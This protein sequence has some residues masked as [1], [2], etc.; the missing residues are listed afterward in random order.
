MTDVFQPYVGPR[1]FESQDLELFFARDSEANELVSLI[2]SHNLVLVYAQSGAGKTSLIN[3]KLVPMLTKDEGFEVLPVVRG[4]RR[5]LP[6]GI[7]LE[8]I[9]S[10]Y[11]FT[12]LINWID[13][14][15]SGARQLI[16]KPMAKFFAERPRPVDEDGLPCHRAI[17]F[18]QFEEFFRLY[19]ER[20]KDREDFFR[21]LS[22]AME[23]EPETQKGEK[24]DQ[25]QQGD[26][27]LHVVL[28][29]RED[30]IASL[31]EY[32]SY[33]PGNLRS[34]FRLEPLREKA[35]LSAI[36]GPLKGTKYSWGKAVPET[37]VSDLL[38]NKVE[39]GTGE[40]KEV[41]GKFVEPLQLQV[42][43]QSL[44]QALPAGVSQIT[45]DHLRDYGDTDGALANFYE[46]A[47]KAAATETEVHENS[48]REWCE[49]WLI[50]S[51]GTRGFVHRDPK[52]T[53]SQQK[54]LA[55]LEDA[56]LIRSEFRAGGYWYELSHDRFVS[57]IKASNENWNQARQAKATEVLSTLNGVF[58]V[59]TSPFIGSK[60]LRP[61]LQDCEKSLS[62]SREIGEG[63]LAAFA[64]GYMGNIYSREKQYTDALAA[65]EQAYQLERAAGDQ[66]GMKQ[67][68]LLEGDVYWELERFEEA[69]NC[70]TEYIGLAPDDVVGYERRAATY[71]YSGNH[72]KAIADYDRVIELNSNTA[73][74]YNGR[75][76]CLT[77]IAE[78]EEAI[79]NLDRAIELGSGLLLAYAH[80]GR[81]LAYAGLGQLRAFDEFEISIAAAPDNAWVYFNRARAFE[82]I[83]DY[84]RAIQD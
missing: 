4:F 46:Q 51:T 25:R 50:T 37:L 75:G 77:D 5:G 13:D 6:D 78:Y 10:A 40:T 53:E 38:K 33:L 79:T 44:W 30:Y 52:W 58:Q 20:Y 36:T 29:M 8:E 11:V 7:K 55:K 56:H 17:I 61:C 80:N 59:L 23:G 19:P 62:T 68:G 1:P 24:Q 43:C 34:R 12:A 27:F 3:A 82:M 35:A 18:D 54:A 74:A 84:D 64:L 39:T 73:E 14:S 71:W 41:I 65:Y 66:D 16:K 83:K 67:Y 26:P 47:L 28:V 49:T 48:L 31:D 69:A 22:V 32:S 70:F 63:K 9:S 60:D 57:P 45:S 42:V 2:T 76:H 72:R 21:Q 81:A 15:G